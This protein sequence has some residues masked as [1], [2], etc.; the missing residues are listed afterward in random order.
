MYRH[1]IRAGKEITPFMQKAQDIL[2]AAGFKN[3]QITKKEQ[4]TIQ[5]ETFS[6]TDKLGHFLPVV[7]SYSK[8]LFSISS[9]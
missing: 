7:S 5:D 3:E 6:R 1:N 2:L 9:S 8:P 4:S